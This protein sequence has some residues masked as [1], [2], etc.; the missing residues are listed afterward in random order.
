MKTFYKIIDSKA[1]VGSGKKVP[2]GYTEYTVDNEPQELIDGLI[3][4]TPGEITTAKWDELNKFLS[5]LTV[6]RPELLPITQGFK[7]S[8]DPK[9]IAN[10]SLEIDTMLD[11]DTRT[12]YEDW[13]SDTITK[14]E[15]QEA[16]RLAS[17]AK[18]AKLAELFG[19]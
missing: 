14:Q 6:Q 8:A 19:V 12:W 15:L 18:Q 16:K 5:T 9:S 3:F 4:K 17:D 1:I 13:G 2:V 7:F 11:T 10:I